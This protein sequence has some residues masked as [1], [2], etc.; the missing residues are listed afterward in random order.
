MAKRDMGGRYAAARAYY[1]AAIDIFRMQTRA[2]GRATNPARKNMVRALRSWGAMEYSLRNEISAR[3]LLQWGVD[4]AR[5]VVKEDLESAGGVKTL[6]TWAHKEWKAGNVVKV[7]H[8]GVRGEGRGVVVCW[9]EGRRTWT[10][11]ATW[12]WFVKVIEDCEL[13]AAGQANAVD[14]AAMASQPLAVDQ[15]EGQVSSAGTEGTVAVARSV[16]QRHKQG[17]T[18]THHQTLL[19]PT[20]MG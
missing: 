8:T 5:V 12:V 19:V 2:A 14:G 18:I 13:D 10:S 7:R 17:S 6:F 1:R 9:V 16:C 15:G 4:Q 11:P 20:S 3:G